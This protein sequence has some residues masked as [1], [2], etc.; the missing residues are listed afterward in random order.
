MTKFVSLCEL[1]ADAGGIRLHTGQKYAWGAADLLAMNAEL[2]HRAVPF[3]KKLVRFDAGMTVTSAAY[4]AMDNGYLPRLE[5][6]QIL[7]EAAVM[8]AIEAELA[9]RPVYTVDDQAALFDEQMAEFEDD[10]RAE[11]YKID[12][13]ELP[14]FL[15]IGDPADLASLVATQREETMAELKKS[16]DVAGRN[17]PPGAVAQEGTGGIVYLYAV[18]YVTKKGRRGETLYAKAFRPGERRHAWH[19]VFASV[20]ERAARVAEFL[21]AVREGV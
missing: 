3:R 15:S 11:F 12:S 1:I 10:S 4:L 2:W 17:V 13:D 14:E 7:D 20:E 9:G 18:P 8:D 6:G 21:A 19:H 16:A 5:I